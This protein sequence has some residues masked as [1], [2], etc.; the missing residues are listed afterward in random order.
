[1]AWVKMIYYVGYLLF[2]LRWLA[3][4]PGSFRLHWLLTWT[5]NYHNCAFS[6]SIVKGPFRTFT[7]AR[8]ISCHSH[9]SFTTQ[10]FLQQ[11]SPF[12]DFVIREPGISPRSSG[13]REQKRFTKHHLLKNGSIRESCV[14]ANKAFIRSVRPTNP[15]YPVCGEKSV[16]RYKAANE[17]GAVRSSD[18]SGL[19]TVRT[20]CGCGCRT[21]KRSASLRGSRTCYFPLSKCLEQNY[22]RD[23]WLRRWSVRLF[24]SKNHF[25]Q[26]PSVWIQ[27]QQHKRILV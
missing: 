2:L 16:L 1:M 11:N 10:Y 15:N 22:R 9:T 25:V 20:R 26:Y 8:T 6:S 13:K 14:R 18:R 3:I 23:S 4:L 12:R 24:S 19:G 17:D 5:D 7:R 27:F 21:A